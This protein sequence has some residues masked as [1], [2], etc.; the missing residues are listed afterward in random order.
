MALKGQ[1]LC[2]FAEACMSIYDRLVQHRQEILA[3]AARNGAHNVRVFGSV[4][5]READAQSDVDFIVDM[6]PGRSLFDMGKLLVELES[7]LGCSVDVITEASLYDHMRER[8][9]VEAI[10]VEDVRTFCID[11]GVS[12]LLGHVVV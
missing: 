5:R 11:I 12:F 1:V 10:P 8:V 4:A 3:I 6:E 2:E 9:L 7:L